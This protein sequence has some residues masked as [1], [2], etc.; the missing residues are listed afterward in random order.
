MSHYICSIV[1][2]HATVHLGVHAFEKTGPQ[3]ILV[4]V[5][6]TIPFSV[7]RKIKHLSDTVDYEPI[8]DFIQS[9]SKREHVELIE[10]LLHDLVD[11]CFSDSRVAHVE[12][13][14]KKTAVFSEVEAVG[15]GINTSR[16]DWQQLQGARE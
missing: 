15:I 9:W 16:N 7:M 6:L 10:H 3:D 4:N 2:A 14:I 8:R 1:D 11:F 12:A 13:S 5:T